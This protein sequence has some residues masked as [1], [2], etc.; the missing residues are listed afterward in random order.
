MTYKILNTISCSSNDCYR[1]PLAKDKGEDDVWRQPCWRG[2]RPLQTPYHLSLSLSL[3]LSSLLSTL[4]KFPVGTGQA[5]RHGN[6][7]QATSDMR[8]WTLPRPPHPPLSFPLLPDAD[9]RLRGSGK[10]QPE[11]VSAENLYR[12]KNPPRQWKPAWKIFSKYSRC[13][14]V[15][16]YK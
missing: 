14:F 1:H 8:P 15:V 16:P 3:S 9:Q 13:I 11:Y 5:M 12:N 2:I 7:Q 10:I 4:S 6:Q